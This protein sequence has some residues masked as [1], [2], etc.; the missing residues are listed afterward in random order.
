[1]REMT[2]ERR[3]LLRQ[4]GVRDVTKWA[5]ARVGTMTASGYTEIIRTFTTRA[6]AEREIRH[7]LDR[8]GKAYDFVVLRRLDN[9]KW[10]IA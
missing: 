3:E 2:P 10:D 5:V 8:S 6:R 4:I 9:G 7:V 1:V